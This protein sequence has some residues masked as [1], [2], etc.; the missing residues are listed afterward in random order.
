[1]NDQGEK[2]N[3]I[4]EGEIVKIQDKWFKLED[5]RLNRAYVASCGSKLFRQMRD[6]VCSYVEQNYAKKMLKRRQTEDELINL[7]DRSYY[8]VCC[9]S[10]CT[11]SE[12]IHY[13]PSK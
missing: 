11:I 10:A 2:S 1:M 4:T 5:C 8:G 6:L 12:F 7:M 9:T 3:T 13:C